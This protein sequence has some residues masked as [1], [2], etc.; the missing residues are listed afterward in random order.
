[1]FAN[2]FNKRQGIFVM[3]VFCKQK[4]LTNSTQLIMIES[5]HFVYNM[6]TIP[7]QIAFKA[8]TKI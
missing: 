3:F 6:Y 5:N 4:T 1:M 2:R 7:Y 8:D